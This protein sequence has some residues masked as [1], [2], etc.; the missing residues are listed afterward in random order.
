VTVSDFHKNENRKSIDTKDSI[1]YGKDRIEYVS[2][3]KDT[4]V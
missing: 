2:T 3:M 4:M 1:V